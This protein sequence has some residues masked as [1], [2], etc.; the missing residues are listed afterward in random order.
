MNTDFQRRADPKQSRSQKTIDLILKTT[1]ELLNEVGFERLSTNLVCQRAGLT[2]PAIYR[3]FPNKYALLSELGQRLMDEQNAA[4]AP[5]IERVLQDDE[6]TEAVFE[7]ISEQLEI[8]ERMPGGRWILRALHATPA[9]CD[10]RTRSHDLVAEQL[11]DAIL[12]QHPDNDRQKVIQTMRLNIEFGYSVIE[13]V[14]DLPD[15]DRDSVL[16]EAANTL[17]QNFIQYSS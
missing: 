12:A 7:S 9:L 5:Y 6:P 14:M 11:A 13:Y 8:A 1:S 16:R 2:P 17:T 4:L 15:V 10:I 3:Y